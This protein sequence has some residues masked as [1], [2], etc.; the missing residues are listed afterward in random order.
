MQRNDAVNMAVPTW[1]LHRISDE[2]CIRYPILEGSGEKILLYQRC[3][4]S[5]QLYWQLNSLASSS[6]A[7]ISQLKVAIDYVWPATVNSLP[8]WYVSVNIN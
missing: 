7:P 3:V 5:S 4:R 1:V 6:R 8:D 2:G